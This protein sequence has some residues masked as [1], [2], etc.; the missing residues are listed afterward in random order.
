MLAVVSLHHGGRILRRFADCC[1]FFPKGL[2][3]EDLSVLSVVCPLV[4]PRG[5]PGED[6]SVLLVVCP[7]VI[8]R[9]L[10]GEDLSV[11]LV[12]CPLVVP[13]GLPGEDLFRLSFTTKCFVVFWDPDTR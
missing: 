3:A 9:G 11:F 2:P 10:P 5:L 12:V 6:L 8:P 1:N 7:L 4:I 13:R